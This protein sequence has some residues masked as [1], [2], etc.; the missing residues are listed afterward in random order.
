MEDE[1]KEMIEMAAVPDPSHMMV[2]MVYALAGMFG[3][4]GVLYYMF[5]T[6][7][8]AVQSLFLILATFAP[9]GILYLRSLRATV[10]KQFVN[11]DAFNTDGVRAMRYEKKHIIK[12]NFPPGVAEYLIK[13]ASGKHPFDARMDIVAMDTIIEG[14]RTEPK[15]GDYRF[16]PHVVR[17]FDEAK[18]KHPLKKK[19]EKVEEK[20]EQ[21]ITANGGNTELEI[22]LSLTPEEISAQKEVYKLTQQEIVRLHYN[23]D[24]KDIIE[25]ILKQEDEKLKKKTLNV[26]MEEITEY[27][28]PLIE[29]VWPDWKHVVTVAKDGTLALF[30]LPDS[31]ENTFEFYSQEIDIA[32]WFSEAS[33][34]KCS[35]IFLMVVPYLLYHEQDF[36]KRVMPVFLVTDS[37]WHHEKFMKDMRILDLRPFF[38][39]GQ[40]AINNLA[41]QAVINMANFIGYYKDKAD[42]L[43]RA[44]GEMSKD[45]TDRSKDLALGIIDAWNTSTKASTRALGG[46]KTVLK[47]TTFWITI[48][49]LAS[50]FFA[51]YFW[52]LASYLGG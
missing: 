14:F 3:L 28:M 35:G 9:I 19:R 39:E 29:G 45:L 8:P 16:E 51:L 21:A 7:S 2:D 52:W 23:R 47:S 50:L 6:A 36:L 20:L 34:A 10:G 17:A 48:V 31:F 49:V 1:T 26:I 4:Y 27:T 46:R 40:I 37:E 12:L 11:I 41:V 42:A 22:M 43:Q 38:R 33:M 44:I 13:K 32:G 15:L 30:I 24:V 25:D 18:G 5:P